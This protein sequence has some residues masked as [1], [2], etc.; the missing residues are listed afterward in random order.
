MIDLCSSKKH[1]III[2]EKKKSISIRVL[3][4]HYKIFSLGIVAKQASKNAILIFTGT[5]FGA[6]NT[7]I[8]LPRAF[9]DNP[10]GLGFIG[11]M[12]SIAMVSAQFFSLSANSVFLNFI[13]K[14]NDKT[15]VN[16]LI[17]KFLSTCFV[18]TLILGMGLMFS[19]EIANSWLA[20]EDKFLY[21]QYKGAIVVF[22]TSVVFFY[23]FG[24]VLTAQLQ[25]VLVNFLIDPFTKMIYLFVALLFLFGVIDY[26]IL[27]YGIVGSYA[28]ISVVAAIQSYRS[29]WRVNFGRTGLPT[30]EIVSYSLYSLLDRS[31]GILVQ[32]IDILMIAAILNFSVAAEYMVAFFIGSVVI[33]PFRSIQ[34]IANPIISKEI[35]NSNFN[36][37]KSVYNQSTF[38]AFL[39]GAIV[40][41]GVWIN[42]DEILMI[43]PEKFRGGKWIILFIG[44][45]KLF[46]ALGSLS[47]GFIVYSSY[48]RFILRLNLFLLSLTIITDLLLI[49][50][51]GINGAA[52][53]T[54]LT[55]LVFNIIKV[56]FVRRKFKL[57]P[58]NLKLIKLILLTVIVIVGT[59]L[60]PVN[61][62]IYLNIFVKSTLFLALYYLGI[63]ALNLLPEM[64]SISEIRRLISGK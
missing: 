62:N 29:G 38:F 21:S 15:K 55:I 17:T 54:A 4:S 35:G 34:S 31:A 10:A 32:R 23:A 41:G 13:P 50:Y 24:G 19:D 39:L 61:F 43:L 37:L 8:V 5:L 7:V 12:V 63:R 28:L 40:F 60:V 3:N 36:Q 11:V 25:T 2:L 20:Q 47:A 6:V 27:I 14:L 46:Q 16:A 57:T 42:V 44:L 51:Y 59:S 22:A 58:Y 64:R 56:E 26:S 1:V 18:S 45:S 9:E 49:T 52:A 48:Y 53:A 33:I 30:K